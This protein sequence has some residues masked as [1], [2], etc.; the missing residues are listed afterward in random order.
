VVG[1][2]PFRT[3]RET[4]LKLHT[5]VALV[6]I[7][8]GLAA[9]P[10][11]S[12]LSDRYDGAELPSAAASAPDSGSSTAAI[13][14][15]LIGTWQSEGNSRF[16]RTFAVDGSV[17]DR[18]E[19]DESST[20]K[21]KWRLFTAKD[22]D[23]LLDSVVAGVTYLRM[24]NGSDVTFYAIVKADR[25]RLQLRYADRRGFMLKFRRVSGP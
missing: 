22:R 4:S 24:D 6:S 13:A 21:A 15:T 1:I 2:R 3:G 23:P 25:R 20:T 16:T 12:A 9:Q 11:D 8:G 14:Q 5:F 18:Y 19:G 7:L 17:T 10:A